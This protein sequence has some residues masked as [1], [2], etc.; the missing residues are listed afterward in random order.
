[1]FH[2]LLVGEGKDRSHV[3]PLYAKSRGTLPKE[4]FNSKKHYGED[5]VVTAAG[6]TVGQAASLPI[7]QY[8]DSLPY[9]VVC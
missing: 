2:S 1:L 4:S 3:S 9:G 8:A 5:Y 6:K 7:F